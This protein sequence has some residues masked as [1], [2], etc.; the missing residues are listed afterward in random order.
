MFFD[1]KINILDATKFSITTFSI[2]TLN[3][4]SLFVTVVSLNFIQH[5]WPLALK[6]YRVP[7]CWVSRFI[8]CYAEC[9]YAECWYAECHYAECRYAECRGAI[10]YCLVSFKTFLVA[11]VFLKV[12]AGNTKGGKYHCTFDLLFDWFGISCM[13][14]DN[15]C[16]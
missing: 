15:F 6:T 1:L 8:Y 10:F 4:K 13:T 14:T 9:H 12:E 5:N 7:L 3:L 11:A 2:M 16:F